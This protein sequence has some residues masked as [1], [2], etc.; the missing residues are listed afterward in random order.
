MATIKLS[1]E[2][3]QALK[4][5]ALFLRAQAQWLDQTG[6][7]Q[8]LPQVQAYVETLE[9]LGGS[10]DPVSVSDSERNHIQ[11]AA[12]LLEGARNSYRNAEFKD[13]AAKVAS[14]IARLYDIVKEV[15]EQTN[16]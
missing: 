14:D 15:N 16:N 5:T 6:S 9:R 12:F 13:R 1:D 3:R 7:Q 10:S 4:R 11:Q 8:T 2:T